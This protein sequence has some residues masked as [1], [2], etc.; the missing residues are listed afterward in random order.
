MRRILQAVKKEPVYVEVAKVTDIEKGKMKNIQVEGMDILV[1][2]VDGKFYAIDDRCGHMNALLSMG[3]LV[4]K[5]V[6]CPFHFAHF[7]VTTGKRVKDPVSEEFKDADK[8]PEEMQNFLNYVKTLV[9]PVKTYDIQSY[10]LKIEGNKILL[11]LES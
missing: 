9:D 8:L 4:G 3:K 5:N 11:K 7:D 2:N 1:A 10:D 6:I